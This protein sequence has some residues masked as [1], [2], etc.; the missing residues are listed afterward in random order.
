MFTG[1]QIFALL[2]VSFQIMYFVKGR[3]NKKDQ[4][5]IHVR[6]SCV[7][8]RHNLFRIDGKAPLGALSRS[9]QRTARR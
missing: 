6:N 2:H 7:L 5:G 9:S 8:A 3:V 4:I 1:I